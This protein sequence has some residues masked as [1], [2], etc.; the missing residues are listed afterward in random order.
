M[1][2]EEIE[3]AEIADRLEGETLY[4]TGVRKISGGYAVTEIN[5][6]E[7][8]SSNQWCIT[9]KWGVQS[10]CEN[11]QHTEFWYYSNGDGWE[12]FYNSNN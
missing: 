8:G 12:K 11:T 4:S 10:D 5:R 7:E 3:V 1:D 9:L 6:L 2:K